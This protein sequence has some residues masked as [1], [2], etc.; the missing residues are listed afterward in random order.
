MSSGPAPADRARLGPFTAW[1]LPGLLDLLGEVLTGDAPSRAAFRDK[2][3]L[4]PGFRPDD[5]VLAWAGSNL[6]GFCHSATEQVAGRRRGWIVALGVRSGYRRQGLGSALLRRA[7][8]HLSAGGCGEIGVSGYADRYLFPGVDRERYPSAPGLFRR[9]GF[10]ICGTAFAMGRRLG[11]DEPSSNAE[12][13]G[14]EQPLDGDLPE[15]LSVAR[16]IRPGWE[17]LLAGY[18]SRSADHSRL[19]IARREGAIVGFAAH[20]IFV[21][22]PGRYGPMGVVAAHRGRGI[23]GQLLRASLASM[24]SLGGTRAWFLWG[25]EEEPGQQMYASAGFVVER[26]F[27]LYRRKTDPGPAHTRRS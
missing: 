15:L 22:Q 6:V 9:A 11:S 26:R 8:E 4:D 27:D 3:L 16:V 25:P 23:G 24:A 21:D 10:E 14:C 12:D 19:H 7:V 5:L 1:A 17:K 18:L 13:F 2:V 20:E